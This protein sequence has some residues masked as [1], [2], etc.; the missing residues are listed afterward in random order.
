MA[1]D[2]SIPPG[3]TYNPSAWRERWPLIVLAA[4]GLFASLYIA[5][6]QVGVFPSM[7]DPF[8][9]SASAHAVT[10]SAIA[11]LSPAPDGWLGVAGY[12]CDLIFGSIG[13]R[14]RW[15]SRPWAALA[16]AGV[17]CVLGLVSLA[18]TIIQGVIIGHWCTVCLLSAAVSTAILAL[19]I[20]EALA[21]LQF[22][23]LTRLHRG[24]PATFRALWGRE[25]L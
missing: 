14:D 4:I 17:I 23:A 22:L 9:G 2:G 13:G 24:L 25:G 5:L 18:L 3:W 6:T 20:G 10:H 21:T 19:G 7:W 1:Q 15:R 11:R 16:F 8:F 12:V